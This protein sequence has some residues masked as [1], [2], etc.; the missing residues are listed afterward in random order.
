MGAPKVLLRYLKD[1]DPF[2]PDNSSRS[3]SAHG[4]AEHDHRLRPKLDV[5]EV[6]L[7]YHPVWSRAGIKSILH[8]HVNDPYWNDLLDQAWEGKQRFSSISVSWKLGF[9]HLFRR[10]R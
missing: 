10:V 6:V 3:L 7:P 4:L 9:S 5:V 1:V 2:K 8:E